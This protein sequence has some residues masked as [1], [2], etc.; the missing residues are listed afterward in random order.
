[1]LLTIGLVVV[2]VLNSL[3]V[4]FIG[5]RVSELLRKANPT[6]LESRMRNL[7]TEWTVTYDK[8]NRLAGRLAK[9]RGLREKLEDEPPPALDARITSV[10]PARMSR[11]ELLVRR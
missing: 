1:M 9:E 10:E 6:N 8:I 4:M 7:E 2:V 3:V 5:F 11:A